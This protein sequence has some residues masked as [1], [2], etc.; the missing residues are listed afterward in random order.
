MGALVDGDFGRRLGHEGRALRNETD[1]HIK[2]VSESI[3]AYSVMWRYNEKSA[4][5]K[6]PDLKFPV[7]RTGGNK[8]LLFKGHPVCGILLRQMGG[9]REEATREGL[10]QVQD[11]LS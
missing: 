2:E 10:K 9:K 11:T 6:H 7:S 5:W 4:T 3:L 8:C 1:P